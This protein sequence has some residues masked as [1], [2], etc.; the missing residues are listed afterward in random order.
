MELHQLQADWQ[1]FGQRLADQEQLSRQWRVDRGLR[2]VRGSLRWLRIGLLVQLLLGVVLVLVGIAC[3]SRN[4]DVSALLAVGILVH[5]FGVLTVAMAGGALGLMARIDYAAPVLEITRQMARL[6]RF[7]AINALVC[8]LPWWIMWLLVPLALIGTQPQ[9]AP[10]AT[11]WVEANLWLG[12]VGLLVSVVALAWWHRREVAAGRNG[13][14]DGS[15]AIRRAHA[16]LRQI[17]QFERD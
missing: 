16:Q 5:V 8:G 6:R 15:A 17:E 3:W 1:S 10:L 2:S 4:L 9:A 14:L 7:Q 13:L 11:G 12:G